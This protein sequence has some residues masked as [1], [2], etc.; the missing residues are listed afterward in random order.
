MQLEKEL[1]NYKLKEVEK[2]Q[3]EF[4]GKGKKNKK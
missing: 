1:N 3:Q 2:Q 4:E